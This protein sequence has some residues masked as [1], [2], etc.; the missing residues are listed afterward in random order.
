VVEEPK[1]DIIEKLES[2]TIE[3]A[4][5]KD[6]VFDKVYRQLRHAWQVF[7]NNLISQK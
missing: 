5:E 4:S 3:E 7:N 6:L 2:M 1:E